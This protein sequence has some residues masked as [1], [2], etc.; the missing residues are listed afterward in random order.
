MSLRRISAGH[1]LQHKL[2][3]AKKCGYEGVEIHYEDLVH[4]AGTSWPF[5]SGHLAPSAAKQIDAAREI[6][7]QCAK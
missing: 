6:F 3:M 4:C 2:Y 1:R 7:E 5:D